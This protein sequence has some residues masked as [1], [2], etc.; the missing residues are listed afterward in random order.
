MGEVV[1]RVIAFFLGELLGIKA[2]LA[3]QT[4]IGPGTVILDKTRDT[5]GDTW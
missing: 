2:E 1:D 3:P 4:I 5:N